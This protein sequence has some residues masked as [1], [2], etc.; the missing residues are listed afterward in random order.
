MS[1]KTPNEI[2]DEVN[3]QIEEGLLDIDGLKKA[4]RRLYRLDEDELSG[5]ESLRKRLL[6]N[7]ISEFLE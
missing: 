3:S 1:K 7:C 6:L 2:M 4:R 5:D